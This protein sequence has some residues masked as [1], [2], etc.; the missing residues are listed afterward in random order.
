[1]LHYTV[2]NK[3]N[4]E[5]CE[6][7]TSIA[8]DIYQLDEKGKSF[9]VLDNNQGKMGIPKFFLQAMLAA[10]DSCPISSIQVRKEAFIREVKIQ[11]R[12]Y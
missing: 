12:N 7:C 3:K 6:L 5:S 8:P 10:S 9:G 4:C 2:V 1:M 11:Y